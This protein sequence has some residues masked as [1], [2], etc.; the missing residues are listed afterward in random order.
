M[1][2]IYGF[3]RIRRVSGI[4]T[5]VVRTTL[6]F[7]S[8][9]AKLKISVI[10]VCYNSEA[11]IRD[12]IESVLSQ[13]YRDIEYIIIDGASTDG[14][15]GIVNEYLDKLG[16]VSSESD[17]GLWDAMNKGI[18]MSTG[19]YICFINSDDFFSGPQVIS[20][21]A[22]HVTKSNADAVFGYVD[23]VDKNE[24]E[25]VVRRYRISRCSKWTFRLGMM[26]AHP[27]FLARRDLFE[28]LGGFRLD[29]NDVAPDF[30]LMLRFLTKGNMRAALWPHVI[31]KMRNEGASNKSF[32][33][34]L[35]RYKILA[36]SCEVNDVWTTPFLIFLKFP[37]KLFEYFRG[38]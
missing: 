27:G 14:T 18:Q 8:E 20:D 37:Y 29:S 31:V 34:R 25:K 38:A 3:C 4:E 16:K 23:I 33:D 2:R 10:T 28:S 32:I 15:M 19:E 24:L 11:T 7:S 22:N 5:L 35:F 17:K 21:L 12:T 36:K 30:E 1:K 6:I 9:Q 13:T 26:P